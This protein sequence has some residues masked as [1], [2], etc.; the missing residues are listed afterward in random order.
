MLA[1]YDHLPITP[2]LPPHSYAYVHASGK[3]MS[4]TFDGLDY[5]D[6]LLVVMHDENKN[7]SPDFDNQGVPL[8]GFS[9]VNIENADFSAGFNGVNLENLKFSFNEPEMTVEAR[10]HYPPFNDLIN[11]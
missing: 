8:E 9:I 4:Y 6:Y 7:H 11:K 1:L 3:E 2:N 5:G 10:M